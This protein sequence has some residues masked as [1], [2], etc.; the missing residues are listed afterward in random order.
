[1]LKRLIS[2]GQTGVDRAAL[3][4]AIESNFP[5]GG[6]CPAGR[7]AEDG[8]IPAIYLLKETRSREYEVRT[9]KNVIDSDGTLILAGG[10][11]TGGTALTVQFAGKHKKPCLVIDVEKKN[12]D[13]VPDIIAWL[14]AENIEVL[15]AAG[16]RASKNPGIYKIAK[17]IVGGVLAG[18]TGKT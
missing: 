3:D 17:E 15:N 11:P 1:M 13:S 6:W 2:G 10:E 7:R 14:R 4:A 5:C 12:T 18:M 8:V 9:E 16:P